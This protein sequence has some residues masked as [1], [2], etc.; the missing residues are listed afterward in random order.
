MPK[1]IIGE[2][3]DLEPLEKEDKQPILYNPQLD[4]KEDDQQIE[5]D[6]EYVRGNLYDVITKGQGALD[7]LLSVADQS[8]NPRAYEVV[9]GMLKTLLDANKDLL[10]MHEKKKKLKSKEQP[11]E[12]GNVTN[13]NLFVGST[14]DL[15]KMIKDNNE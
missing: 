9:S 10:D 3:L 4:T 15:L 11:T 14:N 12:Q 1:D 2:V 7:E 13:N 6:A 8:Q 5:T